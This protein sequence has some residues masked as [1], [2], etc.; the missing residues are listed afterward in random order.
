[1]S[2]HRQPLQVMQ[3]GRYFTLPEGATEGVC[4]AAA[5]GVRGPRSLAGL[6]PAVLLINRSARKLRWCITGV[7]RAGI[8]PS[9]SPCHDAFPAKRHFFRVGDA[10]IEPATS[11]V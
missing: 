6:R 9:S 5:L 2:D 7:Q 10:G 8:P 4:E 1:M 3:T 11:A